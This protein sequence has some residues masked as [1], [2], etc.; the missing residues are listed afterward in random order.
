M[1]KAAA[2]AV[3][4]RGGKVA[5]ERS[6]AGGAKKASGAGAKAKGG[7]KGG[8]DAK[9]KPMS[10]LEQKRAKEA[11]KKRAAEEAKAAKAAAEAEEARIAALPVREGV[12][13][14]RYNHY[15]YPV[16]VLCRGE[17]RAPDA[18]A[19][20][21]AAAEAA[22][23]AAPAAAAAASTAAATAAPAAAAATAAAPAAAAA[24]GADS[25]A[26]SE[27]PGCVS[28]AALV[29]E[30]CL[31]LAFK[32]SYVVR[33]RGPGKGAGSELLRSDAEIAA[34]AAAAAAAAAPAAAATSEA[35]GEEEAAA[36][37]AALVA[38]AAKATAMAEASQASS[39][40]GLEIGE[41]YWVEVMEDAVAESAKPRT[42]YKAAAG[43]SHIKTGEAGAQ[44]E[45]GASCSCI[46]GNPCAV[47][48]NCKNWAQRF[49]IATAN[50]WK[51]F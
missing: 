26:R 38:A 32:G 19:V 41:E 18:A 4:K 17:L 23:A 20:E 47:A 46:E 13:T 8:A 51:G 42:A 24:E 15:K 31:H 5:P 28:V 45:D 10:K 12:V 37:A 29:E 14:I 33:L 30:F 40:G 27:L 48:Y 34:G 2:T 44:G 36:A 49:D 16:N 1:K 25:R 22:P 9:A 3:A 35:A 21:G 43:S 6:R 39:V 11:E 50:G 7:A